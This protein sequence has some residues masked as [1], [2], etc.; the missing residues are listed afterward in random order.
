MNQT[1]VSRRHL[2]LGSAGL[3]ALAFAAAPAPGALA[4]GSRRF[5][6]VDAYEEAWAQ[7]DTSVGDNEGGGLAWGTSYV[8]L[9]LVRMYQATGED[10][11]LDRFVEHADQVWALTDRKRGVQD[12]AGRSGWVWRSGGSYTAAA[13]V[14]EDAT[15]G[16]PLFEVRYAGADGAGAEVTVSGAGP[17][18]ADLTLTHS[19][20][21]YELPG[22]SLDPASPD[23]VVTRVNED[24]YHPWYRWT[25]KRLDGPDTAVPETGTLPFQQRSY[26]F[27]AHTGM[28]TFPMALFARV[29]LEEGRARHRGSA[30]KYL[31]WVQKSVAFHEDEWQFRELADGGVG[32]D[33]VW[34]KGAP[35]PFDG[36]IQPFNQ[37]QAL[38]QTMAELHR[39]GRVPGMGEK[40]E[41]MIRS[42]R[43]DVQQEGEAW[44]WHY[45]PTYSEM[46]RGPDAEEQLSEYTPWYT[47]ATQ[48]EDISH[49]AITVEML[50]AAHGAGLEA[51]EEDLVALVHT[52]HDNVAL[53]PDSVATR[54]SGGD[55][56]V[57][58]M[59]SQAG[60][61]LPLHP[62]A[63]EMADHVHA[64]Y[65]AYDL[66][67]DQGSHLLGMSNLVWTRQAGTAD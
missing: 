52:Y 27:A 11:Y 39:T 25:A 53:G 47:P 14:V 5:D 15:T 45:W 59:A 19:T 44:Q 38:G 28:I 21:T 24:V 7:I 43:S 6:T 37:T 16:Q 8:L 66:D 12:W 36:L 48:D 49:A 50:V 35:V 18:T 20:G 54:V 46:Y 4:D 56:A 26:V 64:V 55:P 1:T 65:E 34:P 58:S 61:W 57:L 67:P 40:V 3:A 29:V 63:P 30:Q 10:L 33:Y 2:L 17:G 62:L 31:A 9:S 41:A 60:R 23:F 42:F 51:G 32:G 22:V 13:A